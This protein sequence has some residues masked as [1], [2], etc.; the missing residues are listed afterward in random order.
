MDSIEDTQSGFNLEDDFSDTFIN[1]DG[2]VTELTFERDL[3]ATKEEE[4]DNTDESWAED[5][6]PPPKCRDHRRGYRSPSRHHRRTNDS[7]H[8]T[9]DQPQFALV[10]DEQEL[11]PSLSAKPMSCAKICSIISSPKP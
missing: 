6:S 11:K 3:E 7:G 8:H 4:F 1:M 5:L 10:A 2:A 9:A